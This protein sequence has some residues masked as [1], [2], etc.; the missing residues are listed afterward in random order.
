M[1]DG[2]T[3]LT[4]AR[5]HH[6]NYV[7]AESPW[8]PVTGVFETNPVPEPAA[9]S[10]GLERRLFWCQ[11]KAKGDREPSQGKGTIPWGEV[12][13]ADH[14]SHHVLKISPRSTMVVP[15]LGK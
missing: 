7:A 6:R 13:T 14:G 9:P 2:V 8:K 10:Q 11:E 5:R 3:R 12:N 1:T 4:Y 15:A